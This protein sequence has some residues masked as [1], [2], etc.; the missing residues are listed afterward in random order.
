[1]FIPEG[2]EIFVDCLALVD[3]LVVDEELDVGVGRAAGV[4]GGQ[5]VALLEVDQQ[6]ELGDGLEVL[7][8]VVGF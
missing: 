2:V 4:L 6:L 1:M 3:H 8:R 5:V 7:D